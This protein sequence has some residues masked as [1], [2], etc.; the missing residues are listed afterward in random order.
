[1]ITNYTKLSMFQNMKVDNNLIG[2]NFD[3]KKKKRK[4]I[5]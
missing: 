2:N 5:H 4:T 3:N 1:M